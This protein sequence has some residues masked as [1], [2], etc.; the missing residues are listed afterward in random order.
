MKTDIVKKEKA[1]SLR[2]R[3]KSYR[4]IEMALDVGRSTL[5]G[6]LHNIELSDK[7]KGRLHKKW[8]EGLIKARTIAS[9][10]HKKERLLRIKKIKKEASLFSSK[11]VLN[12]N[13][14]ELIFSVFYL[15]EGGK[16]ENALVVA[17]SNPAI[18][19]AFLNLLRFV[20]DI[21]ESKIRCCLHLRRDQ[22]E[23]NLLNFW[24]KNLGVCK[25]QFHKTQFDKRTTKPTYKWYKGVCVVT[26]FNMNLQRKILYIGENLLQQMLNLQMGS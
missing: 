16:R 7:Q 6:W 25:K 15:A 2:K 10:I 5:N 17:N 23:S 21:D 9:E 20:Y 18:L 8:L 24:S 22:I 4:D 19:K 14:G 1:I 26:Y 12:K 13:L 11:V 3:G